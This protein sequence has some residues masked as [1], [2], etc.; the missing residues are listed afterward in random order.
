MIVKHYFTHGLQTK[1]NKPTMSTNDINILAQSL[2]Q[3]NAAE[4]A[5]IWTNVACD[6]SLA[7]SVH[8]LLT[9]EQR[10]ELVAKLTNAEKGDISKGNNINNLV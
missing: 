10:L 6:K 9:H 3:A 7:I 5:K 2:T 4:A 1:E 8:K